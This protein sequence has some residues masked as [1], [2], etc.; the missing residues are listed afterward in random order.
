MDISIGGILLGVQRRVEHALQV[1]KRVFLER[2]GSLGGCLSRNAINLDH[3]LE[4]K[5]LTP[6]RA[7]FGAAFYT[8]FAAMLLFS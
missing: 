8:S 1:S 2:V 7:K 3:F 4:V 5:S 6:S